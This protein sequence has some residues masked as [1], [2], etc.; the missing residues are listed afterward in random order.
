MFLLLLAVVV[1]YA[2]FAR[3]TVLQVT[4]LDVGQGDALYIQSPSGTDVLIDGG[5]NREVVRELGAIMPL[6][7]RS[8][9]VVVATHPDADHIGGLPDVLQRYRVGLIVQSSVEDSEGMDAAA[10]KRALDDE[11]RRGSRF[12]VAERGHV[13]DLGEG[14]YLEVLFPDRLVPDIETNNGSLILRLVYGDTAFLLTGDA[15]DEIEEYL[16][17]L[18]ASRLRSDVLK[19]GHHGSRTSS[20]RLFVGFADPKYAVISRGCDNTYGHPHDEVLSTLALFG[21][22][23]FDTC[24]DGR[25]TF[26]SDGR[27]VTRR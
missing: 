23:T 5:R 19:V 8:I 10:L 16:A 13:I 9:D 14:A 11:M 18:D 26:V 4:F 24:L 22:A 12:L 6:F 7:D 17:R 27:T 1:A 3:P 21:I 2:L 20:S 15:H 25:I